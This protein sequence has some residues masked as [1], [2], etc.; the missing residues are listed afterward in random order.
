MAGL[1][2][3]AVPVLANEDKIGG[4]AISHPEGHPVEC[5]RKNRRVGR[6][7]RLRAL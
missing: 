7:Q 3:N 5:V 4:S 1:F 6:L 2:Y